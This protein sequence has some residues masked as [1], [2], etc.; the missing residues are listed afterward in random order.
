MF[1]RAE[2]SAVLIQGKM[3]DERVYAAHVSIESTREEKSI[4]W[5]LRLLPLFR[6]SL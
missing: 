6:I 4:V 5:V 3:F 2:V 1:S